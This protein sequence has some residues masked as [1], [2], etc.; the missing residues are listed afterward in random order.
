LICKDTIEE[1]IMLLQERKLTLVKELIADDGN[2]FM[3]Q[4][5]RDDLSY[6]LS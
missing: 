5:T 2:A 1:K 3:K 6:L 4:L